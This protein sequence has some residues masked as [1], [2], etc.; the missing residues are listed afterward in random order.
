MEMTR[1]HVTARS[2][3]E[4]RGLYRLPGDDVDPPA[5]PIRD[6]RRKAAEP[7]RLCPA[8]GKPREAYWSGSVDLPNCTQSTQSIPRDPPKAKRTRTSARERS[9]RAFT[10]TLTQT[11]KAQPRG[12]VYRR[13]LEATTTE[14][15]KYAHLSARLLARYCKAYALV[16]I[17]VVHERRSETFGYF[18]Y[19]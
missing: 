14:K 17:C 5:E 18:G 10:H 1:K 2:G 12:V 9:T 11:P 8:P 19:K 3:K 16:C 7:V 6:S 13:N 15:A 4:R